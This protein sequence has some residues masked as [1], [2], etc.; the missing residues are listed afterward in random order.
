MT[1]HAFK[2]R[3]EAVHETLYRAH[4][5]LTDGADAIHQALVSCHAAARHDEDRKALAPVIAELEKARAAADTAWQAAGSA[6]TDL[7]RVTG[8]D[9]ECSER[10]K[11]SEEDLQKSTSE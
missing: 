9:G 5:S 8:C 4:W 2:G 7:I 11:V 6:R 10:A 1:K 3:H